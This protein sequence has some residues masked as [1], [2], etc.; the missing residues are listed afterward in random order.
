M[1]LEF[2]YAMRSSGVAELLG[3]IMGP[4][5]DKMDCLRCRLGFIGDDGLLGSMELYDGA[6]GTLAARSIGSKCLAM[7]GAVAAG[8]SILGEGCC[9]SNWPIDGYELAA[10]W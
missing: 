6:G 7:N 1:A 3:G 4:P 10:S 9:I 2:L 8:M 5:F